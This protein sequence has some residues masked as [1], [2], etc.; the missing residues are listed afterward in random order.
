MT[1]EIVEVYDSRLQ[2]YELVVTHSEPVTLMHFES[3]I[4][5]NPKGAVLDTV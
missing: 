1:Q 5:F 4:F 2:R 3:T